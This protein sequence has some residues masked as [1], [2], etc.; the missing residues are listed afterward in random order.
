MFKLSYC[1]NLFPNIWIAPGCVVAAHGALVM[2]SCHHEPDRES[3]PMCPASAA[4][5]HKPVRT[6]KKPDVK[7]QP[8]RIK[9]KRLQNINPRL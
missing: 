7:F 3:N 5:I 9:F 4:T 8:L 1:A 6:I 2:P